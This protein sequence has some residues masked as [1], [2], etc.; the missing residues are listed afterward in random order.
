MALEIT[1]L[2]KSFGDKKVLHNLNMHLED[3]GIYCLMGP[4]GMG[5]T[6]LLRI[7]MDLE[8]KDSGSI[9]WTE[10]DRSTRELDPDSEISA[11]FQEDR[12]LP[13]LSAIENVNMMYEKKQ[14]VMELSRDL[15]TI[16]PRKCLHQPACEL[17]GGMKRRVSLAR[18]MHFQGKMIILDEPFTGLDMKTRKKVIEYVLRNRR[19]RILLVATHGEEDAEL[20]GAEIIRLEQCQDVQALQKEESQKLDQRQQMIHRMEELLKQMDDNQLEQVGLILAQAQE[21]M[22]KED[23]QKELVSELMRNWEMPFMNGI[24]QEAWGEVLEVLS[25]EKKSYEKGQ[26]LWNV[27]DTVENLPVVLKGSVAAYMVN[28]KGQESEIGRFAD[29][30]CFGEMLAVREIPSPVL[31]RAL[32]PTEVVYLSQEKLRGKDYENEDD[33]RSI[34]LWGII[35]N[36]A[37]KIGIVTDRLNMQNRTIADKLVA[38]LETMPEAEDGSRIMDRTLTELAEYFQVSL[39]SLSREI[40]VMEGKGLIRKTGSKTIKVL[41]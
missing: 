2:C 31:V 34:L 36:M 13:F 20:L 6:T 28:G 18:T 4:S 39:Q 5:K 30:S 40:G 24:P 27:G 19:D 33:M 23:Q 17:S 35:H 16:L 41:I 25:G 29:G 3:G 11:M 10:A 15:S 1:N 12:L 14:S 32:E 38:Y 8:T 26:I 9:R 22:Q 21:E 7:I 37:E